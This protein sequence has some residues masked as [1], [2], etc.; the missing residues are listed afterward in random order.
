V[1]ERFVLVDEPWIPCLMIDGTTCEYSLKDVYQNASRIRDIVDP[2]PLVVASLYRLLLAIHLRAMGSMDLDL[3]EKLWDKENL[4][5]GRITDY[6]EQW[7]GRFDLFNDERPFYQTPGFVTEKLTPVHKLAPERSAGNNKI[8]FDHR[9]DDEPEPVSP[10]EASR[11]LVTAQSY[12]LG[13]GRSATTNFTHS[14]LI[15]KALVV[16]RGS[17]LAETVL[18]NSVTYDPNYPLRP[19]ANERPKGEEDRPS[20]EMDDLEEPG[21]SR[22]PRGYLDYLTWQ[23]RAVRIKFDPNGIK[24]MWYAQGTQVVMADS[25][26]DPMVSYTRTDENGWKPIGIE[27]GK[28]PW[29][30]LSSLIQLRSDTCRPPETIEEAGELMF[31]RVERAGWESNLKVIG[32]ANDKANVSVWKGVAMPLPPR[33]LREKTTVSWIDKALTMAE[34]QASALNTSIW[35]YARY[36]LESRKGDAD[37]DAVRNLQTSLE[38]MPQYW[39]KVESPFYALIEGMAS[40]NASLPSA[41]LKEWAN[42]LSGIATSVLENV[43]S[44]REVNVRTLKAG[45]IARRTFNKRTGELKKKYAEMY[46]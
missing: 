25:T 3:K 8:L 46:S 35:T 22:A 4:E 37:K 32:M 44:S 27:L 7:S 26:L 41:E 29:R 43:L 33:Y 9:L 17:N 38:G 28:E 45:V 11:M 40:T 23:S 13:G 16:L 21:G 12:A 36:T 39:A 5:V 42:T 14:P 20:W 2:S 15:G 24:W 6:L 34:D 30:G 19:L 10:A 18:L 1:K 31:K